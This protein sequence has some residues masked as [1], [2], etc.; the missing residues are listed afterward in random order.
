MFLYLEGLSIAWLALGKKGKEELVTAEH[1]PRA[2]PCLFDVGYPLDKGHC[3]HYFA[4]EETKVLRDCHL[5]K[6]PKLVNNE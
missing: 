2:K 6:V 1:W 3:C 5:P 4:H